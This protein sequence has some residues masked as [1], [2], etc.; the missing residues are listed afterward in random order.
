MEK[1]KERKLKCEKG[2]KYKHNQAKETQSKKTLK[3]LTKT[4]SKNSENGFDHVQHTG[5]GNDAV[6]GDA[7]GPSARF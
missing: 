3:T 4:L 2:K 6:V 7:V 1:K 5:V